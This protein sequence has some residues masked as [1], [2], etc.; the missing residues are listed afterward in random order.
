MGNEII[1]VNNKDTALS[2]LQGSIKMRLR[3]ISVD[4]LK[5]NV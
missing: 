5:E 1:T 4:F 2:A 3:Y